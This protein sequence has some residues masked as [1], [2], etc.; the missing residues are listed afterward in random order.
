MA[1]S[2]A[3]HWH[4]FLLLTL[5]S[6]LLHIAH[7]RD[8]QFFNKI[9]TAINNNAI[10]DEEQPS[11]INQQQQEPSFLPENGN[12]YGLYG[13][14]SGERPH[15]SADTTTPDGIDSKQPLNKYRPKNYNPVAYVTQ[16]ED[17]G[18][19][20][21]LTS[22]ENSNGYANTQQEE[23]EYRSYPTTTP[24]N[25]NNYVN[26][27]G[28]GSSFNS[29][30]L[31]TTE[32]RFMGGAASEKYSN[33]GGETSRYQPQGMSDTRSLESGK[34]FYDVNSDK[35][36]I[37]HPYTRLNG[38]PATNEYSDSENT[39]EFNGENSIGG[40]RNQDNFQ[41]EEDNGLP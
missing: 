19:A 35:Y 18:D 15:S 20:L 32:T 12:R 39:Y 41:D 29:D 3:K 25:R 27:Y 38:V 6:S 33:N 1:S 5:L 31:A 26:Y 11:L 2:S 34:Y 9:P 22:Y 8:S 24:N 16:P 14:E 23:E 21:P 4:P 40:Y 37:N 28:R 30:P 7:A 17:F 36:S 13:Q 10:P